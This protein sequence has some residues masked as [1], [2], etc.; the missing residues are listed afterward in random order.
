MLGRGFLPAEGETPG[1][2]PVAVI[3]ESL[4]RRAVRR[5]PAIVGRPI[6]LNGQ[7]FTIIGVAPPGF[8]GSTAGLALDVFV[9]ITMQ[10]AIMAG[11][12]L[13]QR[14]SSFLAGVRAAVAPVRTWTVRRRQRRSSR[15]AWP[16]QYPETNKGRGALVVPL[17]IVTAPAACCC[18]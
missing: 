3:S 6:T 4:W 13:A 17:W 2:T 8:H 1:R 10:K 14:G 5:D 7:S 11:D 9:P 18:R 15:P 16:Q 12:R